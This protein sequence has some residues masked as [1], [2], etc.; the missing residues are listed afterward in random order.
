MLVNRFSS[1]CVPGRLS[2]G[3]GGG[4]IFHPD[5]YQ[6]Y[7]TVWAAPGEFG[8]ADLVNSAEDSPGNDDE[9]FWWDGI[10]ITAAAQRV[11]SE[12][13]YRLV[14]PPSVRLEPVSSNPD[15][16]LSIRWSGGG[17]PFLIQRRADLTADI[18]EPFG[19]ATENREVTV[20]TGDPHAFFRV[21][22]LGQ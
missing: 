13:I 10:H 15:G 8:F 6:F 11:Q 21:L 16:T 2:G 14:T 19:G 7:Q 18:W 17:A 20:S 5:I 1:P 22:Q 9:F 12:E 4:A 3:E